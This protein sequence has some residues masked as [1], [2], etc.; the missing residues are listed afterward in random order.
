M[1]K[2][3][4]GMKKT[5]YFMRFYRRL[6]RNRTKDNIYTIVFI[7]VYII[8][9]LIFYSKVTLEISNI[10]KQILSKYIAIEGLN[11]VGKEF[12]P[13]F[14]PIYYLE[15]PTVYPEYGMLIINI[16][17]CTIGLISMVAIKKI[18]GPMSIYLSMGFI[19]QIISCIYFILSKGKFPYTACDY[20]ELYMKQQL[21]IW[22]FLVIIIGVVIAL[23]GMGNVRMKLMT[24][25]ATIMYSFIFGV[26]RYCIYLFIIFKFSILY[27]PVLFFILGPFFD[28]LYLVF[29]YGL[30]INKIIK[31]YDSNE[32]RKAWKWA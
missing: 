16:I 1:D 31:I 19:V 11:V 24:I 28:F 3:T 23:L 15:V 14:G 7:L 25:I 26:I 4:G 10:I 22:I 9:L 12:I 21:S 18:Y 2:S 6:E 30:Y 27:M 5:I 13:M 8:G 29:F 32:G 17:I 20:S